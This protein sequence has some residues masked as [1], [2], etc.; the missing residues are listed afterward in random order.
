MIVRIKAV[1]DHRELADMIRTYPSLA[2]A[3]ASA[4]FV[5]GPFETDTIEDV[6][7]LAVEVVRQEREAAYETLRQFAP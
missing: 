3:R 5:S 6:W 4:V 2:T 1:V 7:Q